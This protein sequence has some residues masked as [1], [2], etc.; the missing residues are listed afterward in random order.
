MA[1]MERNMR[2]GRFAWDACITIAGHLSEILQS[3][4]TGANM[5]LS[6]IEPD[7]I[8][9]ATFGLKFRFLFLVSSLV[10]IKS[11]YQP[12]LIK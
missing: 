4:P 6:G 5:I 9:F 11:W 1:R 10:S 8:T 2:T 7:A 3:D 12:I